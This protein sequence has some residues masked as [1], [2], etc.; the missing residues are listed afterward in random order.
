MS[1]LAPLPVSPSGPKERVAYLDNARYWV[2][3][4]VVVGLLLGG[5]LGVGTVVYALAIGPL[6]QL[7]LPWC[8]V[9][10]DVPA[11]PETVALDPAA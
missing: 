8:I 3:L 4:L 2:M 5:V 6:T 7:F 9:D 1:A 10:I 11:V